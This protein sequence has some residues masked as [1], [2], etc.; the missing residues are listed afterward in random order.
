MMTLH[1]LSKD[2]DNFLKLKRIMEDVR[3]HY[4]VILTSFK[5][6]YREKH[7]PTNA[8]QNYDEYLKNMSINIV[9]RVESRIIVEE[10]LAWLK[11]ERFR[12]SR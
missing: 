12:K 9:L 3:I 4:T 6:W 10:F 1:I 11:N 8:L 7:Y 2:V 5:N